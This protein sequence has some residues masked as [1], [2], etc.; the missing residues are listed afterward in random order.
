METDADIRNGGVGAQ[1]CKSLRVALFY[2]MLLFAGAW[3]VWAL[4]CPL[5]GDDLVA[6]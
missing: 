1:G 4:C 3:V 6:W 2:P 5:L